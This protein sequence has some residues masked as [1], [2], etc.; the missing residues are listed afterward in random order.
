MVVAAL[1]VGATLLPAIGTG[2][3][4]A[5]PALLAPDTERIQT[6]LTDALTT[7]EAPRN[8]TPRL[9]AA[10]KDKPASTADGCH[11]DLLST[12]T[13]PCVYGS[14]AAGAPVAVLLGDSHAQQ[15]LGGL[16][17]SL[18]RNGWQLQEWTKAACPVADV[19]VWN[20]DLK[21][22]YP[23]CSTWRTAVLKKI[24]ALHP[25]L[26]IASQSDAVVWTSMTNR[27]WADKTAATLRTLAGQ[28]TRIVYLADTPQTT[29]DPLACLERHLSDVRACSYAATAAFQG[30]AGFPDRRLV[31]RDALEAAGIKWVDTLPWFC[32]RDRCPAV[33]GNLT[34]RRD[35]GH[36]T[37]TYATWLAPALA[38]ILARPTS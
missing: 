14:T 22:T 33:V 17:P 9:D 8:L 12:K 11:R 26:I 35:T 3:A 15:W 21:R 10:V 23:E 5:A 7:T 16:L 4:L 38:P 31:L 1:A 29:D 30:F 13:A 24:S 25:A 34:V 28:G 18:R 2:A 32:T 6:I 27:V 19:L 37:N 20:D 36:M